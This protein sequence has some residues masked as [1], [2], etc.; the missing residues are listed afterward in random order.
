[1]NRL[2]GAECGA[3]MVG[4]KSTIYVPATKSKQTDQQYK[5]GPILRLGRNS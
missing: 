2:V 3:V 5:G 1:M 4:E